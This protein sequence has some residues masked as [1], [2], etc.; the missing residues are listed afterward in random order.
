VAVLGNVF[1]VAFTGAALAFAAGAWQDRFASGW[2]A[3]A[4]RHRRVSWALVVAHVLAH[5]PLFGGS[6]TVDAL[7]AEG[8]SAQNLLQIAVVGVAALWAYHLLARRTVPVAA[9]ANGPAFWVTLLIAVYAV[10]TAWSV[11]PELTLFRVVELAVFWVLL[12][13]VFL[14]EDAW[15]GSLRRLLWIAVA[16]SWAS[17]LLEWEAIVAAG[18]LR[19]IA[20]DNVS[21]LVAAALLLLEVHRCIR[22]PSPG[23]WGAAGVAGISVIA[24]GSLTTSVALVVA[25]GVY[26]AVRAQRSARDRELLLVGAL[27][28]A[29]ALGAVLLQPTTAAGDDLA[30]EIA[31]WSGKDV[32]NIQ[33][34]TG[35]LPLWRALLDGTADQP[36]G[37]GFAGAERKLALGFVR[38]S[39]VGWTPSHAHNGFLSGWLGAGWPGLLLSV[40]VFLAVAQR[41]RETPVAGRPLGAALLV[42]LF[43]NNMTA[44]AVG[45]TLGVPWMV[46]M[47]LA[48]MAPGPPSE[49]AGAAADERQGA[50]RSPDAP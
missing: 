50:G 15:E 7:A 28:V 38:V 35:R 44:T 3:A 48:S 9:L 6:R 49:D 30:H 16:A 17:H 14:G 27:V 23:A 21:T 10:S 18:S 34:M 1:V 11:W 32:R 37:L 25:G 22:R 29:A 31:E 8:P 4:A 36:M 43:I 39:V 45:G 19:G 46:M 33:D 20:Y 26:L 5:T 24:F 13:H 41:V 42:L 40:A 47:A 2:T 12:L